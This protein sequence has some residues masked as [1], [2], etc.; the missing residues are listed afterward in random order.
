MAE[1]KN[2][3]AVPY[4]S[5]L[6]TP[7]GFL[8]EPWAKFFRQLSVRIGG[9][10][11][12]TNV[13]LEEQIE[14]GVNPLPQTTHAVVGGQAATN[15]TGETY[16]HTEYLSAT[17][18]SEFTRGTT[19]MT[20]R[21]FTLQYIGGTWNIIDLISGKRSSQVTAHGITLTMNGDQ[22]RA[23]ATAGDDGTIKIKKILFAIS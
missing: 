18:F 15:L 23:A 20:T 4:K 17:V 3:P 16:D 10:A 21:I 6:L 5:Q 8:T 14:S 7:Q 13:E 22:M 2:V 11:A 19:V 12:L 9:Y 1:A